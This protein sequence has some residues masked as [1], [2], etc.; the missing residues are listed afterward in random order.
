MS[1]NF[2]I[3]G[4]CFTESWNRFLRNDQ[5]MRRRLR[6]DVMESEHQVVFVGNLRRNLP[7]DNSFEERL[8]HSGYTFPIHWRSSQTALSEVRF[9][10][11]KTFLAAAAVCPFFTLF[12]ASLAL[13]ATNW[14]T[15]GSR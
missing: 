4:A 7:S 5:D 3:I 11:S 12:H 2:M 1:E 14:R 6:L 9:R 10:E 13:M 15:L 8:G